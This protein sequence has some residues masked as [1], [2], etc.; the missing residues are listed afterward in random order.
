MKNAIFLLSLLLP[1]LA[2]AQ[3][4]NTIYDDSKS[5]TILIGECNIEG[6]RLNE[7]ATWFDK[8]YEDYSVNESVFA[9]T[10]SLKFDSIYVVLGTWCSDSQREVPHFCKIMNH[11]YFKG[12]L[13]RYFAVDGQK[14]TDAIDTE[15][16][17]IQ[18]VPTMIFYYGG[19]EL[20]RIVENPSLS[21][22]KDIM[23]L[24]S[25]IQP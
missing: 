8:E 11:E 25:K 20:C 10:Y 17:Y 12:T 16:F 7:F 18:F 19:N 23:D 24:L 14:H 4:N 3:I 2:N 9:E 5:Q 15:E 21:L 22:E 6:F 13:V 1:L